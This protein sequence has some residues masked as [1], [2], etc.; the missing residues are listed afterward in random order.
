MEDML[1]KADAKT[2]SLD[3]EFGASKDIPDE[4]VFPE[5][6]SIK[7]EVTTRKATPEDSAP[8]KGGYFGGGQ[9]G[10]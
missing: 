4:L 8:Y 5:M 3:H 2:P 6:D 7:Q 10:F 9:G 1:E